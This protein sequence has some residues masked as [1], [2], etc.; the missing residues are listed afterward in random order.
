MSSSPMDPATS[1][2]PS[3]TKPP[4]SAI[5]LAT[6]INVSVFVVDVRD[7]DDVCMVHVG[8][9]MVVRLGGCTIGGGSDD[10]DDNR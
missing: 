7:Y 1:N 6:G 5:R 2:S 4:L 3:F 10:G 9:A 8:A